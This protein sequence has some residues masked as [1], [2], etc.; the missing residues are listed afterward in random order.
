MSEENAKDET[1]EKVVNEDAGNKQPSEKEANSGDKKTSKSS[2][3][4]PCCLIAVI[5]VVVLVIVLAVGGLWGY[6]KFREWL[7]QQQAKIDQS[8]EKNDSLESSDDTINVNDNTTVQ[9]VA[10]IS[11]Y[12]GSAETS[13]FND[14]ESESANYRGPNGVASE[15]ILSYY[16]VEVA[17]KSG[18][19][20]VRHTT[21]KE[22]LFTDSEGKYFQVW[23]YEDNL[24]EGVAYV[25][26]YP[27]LNPNQ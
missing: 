1:S 27:P 23:I 17:K 3:K 8:T 24:V 26:E 10:G 16:E 6:N 21:S 7:D 22:I 19:D 9:S 4:S 15:V 12:P 25:V 20:E 18:W 13:Y 14:N 2:K 11:P 5:V